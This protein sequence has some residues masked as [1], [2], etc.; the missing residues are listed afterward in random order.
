[1]TTQKSLLTNVGQIVKTASKP[2]AIFTQHNALIS[3]LYF[4][5]TYQFKQDQDK[6]EHNQIDIV[7]YSLLFC[8][9]L[10]SFGYSIKDTYTAV[11]LF[12]I[13]AP[14]ILIKFPE[15]TMLFHMLAFI[16]IYHSLHYY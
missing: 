14:G 4:V 11:V 7:K 12:F 10:A 3:L 16:I 15:P 2:R 5:C 13:I 1:M 8:I 6:S 9:C